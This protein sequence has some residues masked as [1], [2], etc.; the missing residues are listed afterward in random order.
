MLFTSAAAGTK[1]RSIHTDVGRSAGEI[2]GAVHV[3]TAERVAGERLMDVV[4]SAVG[5]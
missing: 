4:T 5:G 2:R 1:A 3:P